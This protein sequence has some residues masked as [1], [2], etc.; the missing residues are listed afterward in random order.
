VVDGAHRDTRFL[1]DPG[2]GRRL[3]AV[4]SH[5]ALGGVEDALT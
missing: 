5:D 2:E 3:E 1:H 4:L